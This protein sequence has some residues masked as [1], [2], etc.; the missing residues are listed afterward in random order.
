MDSPFKI[1]VRELFKVTRETDA[2][3]RA[4]QNIAEDIHHQHQPRYQFERWKRSQSG[5]D[6]KVRQYQSQQG[7]C[8]ICR[9]AIALK[10]SHI[11]HL[12]P[13]SLYPDLALEIG[14]LQVTCAD[15]N[16]AKGDRIIAAGP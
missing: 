2:Q 10:G 9:T 4:M 11:D 7:N 3:L 14:N 12:K 8:A 5:R 15:C 6:W 13:L 1:L 16:T